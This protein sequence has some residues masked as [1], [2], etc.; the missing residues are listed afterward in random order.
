M[1]RE[2]SILHPKLVS[3]DVRTCKPASPKHASCRGVRFF[4]G[5][6]EMIVSGV[7]SVRCVFKAN[8]INGINEANGAYGA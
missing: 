3:R 1:H 7:R 4:F 2:V 6:V 8:G 5:H